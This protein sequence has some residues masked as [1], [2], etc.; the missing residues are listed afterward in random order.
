M[1]YVD[2]GGKFSVFG[3]TTSFRNCAKQRT[4]KTSA[5][6]QTKGNDQ[7]DEGPW[8]RMPPRTLNQARTERARSNL[9]RVTKRINDDS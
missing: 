3:T 1:P 4:G 8:Q 5:A 6:Q 7:N 2:I 9:L